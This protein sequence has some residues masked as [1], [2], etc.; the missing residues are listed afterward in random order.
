MWGVGAPR[1]AGTVAGGAFGGGGAGGGSGD[2]AAGENDDG[3]N[4]DWAESKKPATKPTPCDDAVTF[5]SNR[6]RSLLTFYL[7]SMCFR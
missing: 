5:G 2:A 3:A 1:G 6:Q 7:Q 4:G